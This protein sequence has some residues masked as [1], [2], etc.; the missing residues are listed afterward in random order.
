MG[1]RGS[2]A[3][4]SNS[5]EESWPPEGTIGCDRARASFGR[6][7]GTPCAKA[8]ALDVVE[9]AG[10]HAS[11]ADHRGRAPA[12]QNWPSTERNT[13]NWARGQ[14]SHLGAELE[15]AWRSLRRAGWSGTRAQV[16][17]GCWRC[18]QSARES[19]AMRNEAGKECG[20]W[21]GS[22]RE[23]GAWAGDVAEKSVDVREC[24]HAGPRQAR[25]RRN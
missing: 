2:R 12:S 3:G 13:E 17:G 1:E 23:L 5:G 16:S 24:A 25:R 8:W 22:K 15:E 11:T 18:G 19:G 14:V 20:C 9:M 21:R 4:Q 6:G 10:H 7:G